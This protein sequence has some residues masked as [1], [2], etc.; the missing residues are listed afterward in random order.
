MM[1]TD[2]HNR[3]NISK[4]TPTRKVLIMDIYE[5]IVIGYGDGKE[6]NEKEALE[7]LPLKYLPYFNLGKALSWGRYMVNSADSFRDYEHDVK[8]YNEAAEAINTRL[9]YQAVIPYLINGKQSQNDLWK[10]LKQ[11]SHDK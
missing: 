6:Y 8:G 3:R 7:S 5:A 4:E 9:G 1:K 2:N 10:I 11:P